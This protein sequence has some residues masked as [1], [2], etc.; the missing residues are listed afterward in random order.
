MKCFLWK[1]RMISLF[2]IMVVLS[3]LSATSF[4]RNRVSVLSL[5]RIS[6][7]YAYSTVQLPYTDIQGH[8]CDQAILR[9]SERNIL[10]G[11][12]DG[13]FRPDENL[14]REEASSILNALLPNGAPPNYNVFFDVEDRWSEP[15]INR[16]YEFG[17]VRGYPDGSFQPS[18]R[19][20]REEVSA[21]VF[22]YVLNASVL[23][24]RTVHQFAD[25]D[26]SYADFQIGM[27][28]SNQIL[29]GYE[30]GYFLPKKMI[31]RAEF[32]S[33]IDKLLNNFEL[34]P[35][36]NS[37]FITQDA[38]LLLQYSIVSRDGTLSEESYVQVQNMETYDFVKGVF[39]PVKAKRILELVNQARASY[40]LSALEWNT[41]TESAA[42]LRAAEVLYQFNADHLRPNGS[43]GYTIHSDIIGENIAKGKNY[44]TAEAIF[45][46]WMNSPAH[47]ENILDPE[48]NRMSV[49]L[50]EGSDVKNRDDFIS[51]LY[52]YSWVQNFE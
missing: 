39:D 50:F 4:R 31:T 7:C 15:F 41:K 52:Y 20:T 24:N 30:D 18:N 6:E 1:R 9:L 17:L 45:D 3:V 38:N 16:L 11:Y 10:S 34:K 51:G 2:L 13:S 27:L 37:Y 25:T 14:S 33:I 42:Q 35:V 29:T 5:A 8:W 28:R 46:A 36:P 26:L 40:G 48:Y 12:E 19:I 49:A 22:N 23:P 44:N 21:M 32:V 43:K 47:R